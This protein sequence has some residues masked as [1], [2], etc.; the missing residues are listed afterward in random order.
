MDTP[1]FG[2][3]ADPLGNAAYLASRRA[4]AL[5]LALDLGAPISRPDLDA[6]VRCADRFAEIT[7][8]GTRIDRIRGW[9]R[10]LDDSHRALA[11]A[12]PAVRI[13]TLGLSNRLAEAAFAADDDGEAM[14]LLDESGIG[15]L[16]RV[17]VDVGDRLRHVRLSNFN[18]LLDGIVSRAHPRRHVPASPTPRTTTS[19][20]SNG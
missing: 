10:V 18:A 15:E 1:G 16:Q 6:I 12:L 13:T 8:V 5:V 19:A 2:G 20:T 17:L 4:D 3:P 9:Q 7:L 11:A 14:E